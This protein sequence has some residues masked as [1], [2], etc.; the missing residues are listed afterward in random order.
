MSDPETFP[1]DVAYRIA[2]G[3]A[4]RAMENLR[5]MQPELR[6]TDELDRLKAR[7]LDEAPARGP[8]R[9]AVEDAVAGRRPRW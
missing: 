8:A 5:L 6:T 1:V 9:E 7:L 3:D 4:C 2:Y